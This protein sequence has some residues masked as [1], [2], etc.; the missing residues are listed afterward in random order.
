MPE[1]QDRILILSP[2]DDLETIKVLSSEVRLRILDLLTA[3]ASQRQRD[4]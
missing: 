1:V 3:G 4:F 2:R